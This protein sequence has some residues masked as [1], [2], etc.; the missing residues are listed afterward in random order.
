MLPPMLP[1]ACGLPSS[2]MLTLMVCR[3]ALSTYDVTGSMRSVQALN[4]FMPSMVVD[5]RSVVM[6]LTAG[7]KA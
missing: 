5:R 7:S 6:L 1:E 2:P 3:L 4:I